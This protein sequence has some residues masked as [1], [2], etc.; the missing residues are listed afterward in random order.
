M[1]ENVWHGVLERLRAALDP[2]DY[3]RW[4]SGTSYASDSGDQIT[5]WV[6]SEAVRRHIQVHYQHHIERALHA[7]NRPELDVR[8]VV[9]GYG[10]EDDEQ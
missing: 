5:I 9:A 6:E 8:F 10:D 4:F 3:R 2:E 7:L 1:S